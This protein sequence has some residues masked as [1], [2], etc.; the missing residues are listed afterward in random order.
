M[1]HI[2][3]IADIPL[4]G[5]R[6]TY[7]FVGLEEEAILVRVGDEARAYKN[8]CRHLPMRLDEREPHEIWDSSGEHLCCSSHGA[9]Y[10]PGDG[11]CVAGPCRGTTLENV[12]ITIKD[13]SVYFED[14]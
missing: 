4:W 5:H 9:L 8:E 11:Y 14:P 6:F 12:P 2:I 3:K 1:R 10:R 13:G 7:Q